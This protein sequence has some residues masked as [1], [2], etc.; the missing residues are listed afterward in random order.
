MLKFGLQ[1]LKFRWLTFIFYS[2]VSTMSVPSRLLRD[3][4][5]LNFLLKTLMIGLVVTLFT[6]PMLWV[7]CYLNQRYQLGTRNYFYP[8]GLIVTVGA[9]RGE[10]VQLVI[11]GFGLKDNLT[12]IYAIFSSMIFTTI[13]FLVIAS[14]MEKLFQRKEEFNRLFNEASLLLI[15]P[16]LPRAEKLDLKYIYDATL[17]GIK[18]HMSSLNL[19]EGTTNASSLRIVSR[20]IQL[21]INE[22]LRPLS[23]R[24][25]VNG[26]GQVK[27]RNLFGI[28]RDSIQNLD[29]GVRNILAY[30]LFVG[31]YGISL[32]LGVKSSLYVT[33]IGVLTSLSLIYAFF[34]IRK[35]MSSFN[36]ELGIVFLILMALL[37][38]FMPI[39]IRNPLNESA[40]ALAGLLISPTL[41]SL[42]LLISSYRLLA[43][44]RDFAIGAASTVRNK[45]AL[46]TM[47]SSNSGEEIHLAEYFHNSLQSELYGI[48]KRLEMIS[49]S[50][51]EPDG[52]QVIQ[53]LE[54]ALNRNY[55]EISASKVDGIFRI[56]RL[57]DSWKG[58]AE[59]TSSGLDLIEKNPALSNRASLFIEEMITN[60]IRYG[61]ADEIHF[62]LT[63]DTQLLR[64]L[65][66]H[67]G[68]KEFV[69]KSGLGTL[70]MKHYSEA[71]LEVEPEIDK[72]RLRISIP[73]K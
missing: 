40:N 18:E 51:S 29:F 20:E 33:T 69:K 21:Q 53:S 5:S 23:H 12:S 68:K 59:I 17:A 10:I 1:N 37:P 6:L 58:I 45:I 57:V 63:S 2:L 32:V 24:L 14:F 27:H 73:I 56:K 41:P 15:N 16:S 54:D 8:L 62:E 46:I 64:I 70:L 71:G 22:V 36:F 61:D 35:K 38:V 60:T 31:G 7:V 13:Y 43:R 55:E 25:W 4:S 50:P 67:N 65:L 11:A 30:Q 34:F 26:L 19:K 44:D 48:S 42:I 66:T 52:A 3:D 28:L 47:K 9:I 49:N 72:N 39:A